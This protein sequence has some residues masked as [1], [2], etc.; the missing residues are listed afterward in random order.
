MSIID[1]SFDVDFTTDRTSRSPKTAVWSLAK[2]ISC[3]REGANSDEIATNFLL[4]DWLGSTATGHG[5]AVL[6]ATFPMEEGPLLQITKLTHALDLGVENGRPVDLLFALVGDRSDQGLLRGAV[7][8]CRKFVRNA[9]LLN[10]IRKGF[11]LERLVRIGGPT[12]SQMNR[13]SVPALKIA[14]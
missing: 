8:R 9:V 13:F 11:P 7:Q 3:L 14:Q 6:H 4:G 2:R 10:E 5:A 12:P 1:V